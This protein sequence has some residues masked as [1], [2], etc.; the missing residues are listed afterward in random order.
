MTSGV[1]VTDKAREELR[2]IL[3]IRS[4]TSGKCLR[5]AIPPVWTGEGDFGIVIDAEA[6][7]D[8]AVDFQGLTVL[9]MD[10]G[11]AQ[12]LP[13]A[14]LDFKDSPQGPRFTLDVY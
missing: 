3:E 14:V 7:G 5:L 1:T 11:L 8:L 6:E 2:R 10:P 12:Q 9:R 13:T 4:L